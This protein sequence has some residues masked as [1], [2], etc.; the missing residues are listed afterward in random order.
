MINNITWVNIS[1]FRKKKKKIDLRDINAYSAVTAGL[2]YAKHLE[3][4]MN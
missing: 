2:Y 4:F 3:Y 1:S